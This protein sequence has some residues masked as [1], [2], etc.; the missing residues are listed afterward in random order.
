VNIALANEIARLAHDYG[1]DS[2]EAIRLAN[3]H[4]RVDIL[5]P[6]PGVGGHCLPIDPWFLGTDS[7]ELELIS[8]ARQVNDGMAAF[9]IELLEAE[10]TE[11][12]DAKIA[13]LGVAYKG[14]VSDT[15]MSPGLRLAR[16]LG[17]R[18]STAL[19]ADGGTAG[20]REIAIH[21]PHVSDPT[22]DL[23]D[24]ESATRDADAVVLTTDHDEFETLDPATISER[25]TGN[26]IVDTR[27]MLDQ[28]AWAEAGFS[29]LSV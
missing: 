20:C 3:G 16:E 21:D 11:F 19:A 27:A 29:Y 8:T 22:L 7:E 14:N 26:V 13:V 28:T 25:M 4:P 1:I 23:T 12:E 15:R 18:E 5:Q 24:L 2:R 9:V 10:L 17:T 6:G